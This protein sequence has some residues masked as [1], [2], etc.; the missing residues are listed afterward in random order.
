GYLIVALVAAGVA[1]F[2]LQN[3]EPTP[4]HFILW[5]VE[6]FPLAG[7]ILL[8]LACGIVLAGVPLLIQRW[9]L[10]GR[11][12]AAERRVAELDAARSTIHSTSARATG[13]SCPPKPWPA[14]GMTIPLNARAA[15]AWRA[16]ASPSAA[17]G[18]SRY[19][20]RSPITT[21]RGTRIFRRAGQRP[22]R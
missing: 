14:R 21:A 18:R 13:P 8:A 19:S 5:T 10:R 11:L 6:G 12:L 4:V 2:A 1:V 20:S 17:A 22:A 16:N 3:G 9:R 15:V 7:L